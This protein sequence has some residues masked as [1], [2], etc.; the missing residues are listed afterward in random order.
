MSYFSYQGLNYFSTLFDNLG[1]T[2]SWKGLK[3]EPHL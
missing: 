1:N 2:K 3:I